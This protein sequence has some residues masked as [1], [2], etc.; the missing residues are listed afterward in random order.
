MDIRG[1][2]LDL[3]ARGGPLVAGMAAD[4]G[5]H[6]ARLLAA[7]LEA[8]T[9]DDPGERVVLTERALL[10]E[11]LVIEAVRDAAVTGEKAIKAALGAIISTTV[12]AV[13]KE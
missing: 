12:K 1:I 2:A 13:G 9:C 6:L 10:E 5:G 7:R 3:I 4:A 8:A 11:Q